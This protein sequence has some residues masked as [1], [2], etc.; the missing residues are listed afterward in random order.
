MFITFEGGEGTGKSTQIQ[1]L[2][3]YLQTQGKEVRVTREPGGTKIA[4]DI[5]DVLLNSSNITSDLELMLIYAARK[6]HVENLIKPALSKGKYVLCD[7]FADSSLVYQGYVQGIEKESIYSIHNLLLGDFWPDKTF[8]LDMPV[9]I[10]LER[11]KQRGDTNRFDEMGLGFHNKIR[12]GFLNLATE[13]QRIEVINAD[14]TQ[15]DVAENLFSKIN[16]T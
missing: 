6:D 3:Q 13:H 2:A 15:N 12:E 5:R 14:A 9:D 16:L 4:E 10:A 7:R 11:A 1:L 8:L